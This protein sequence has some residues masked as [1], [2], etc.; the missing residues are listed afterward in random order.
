MYIASTCMVQIL[1]ADLVVSRYRDTNRPPTRLK[2]VGSFQ[3]RRYG[4]GSYLPPATS[5]KYAPEVGKHAADM[6]RDLYSSYTISRG[7]KY[8]QFARDAAQNDDAMKHHDQ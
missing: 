2:W 8:I 5:T 1:H 4:S 6:P 3:S 7:Q